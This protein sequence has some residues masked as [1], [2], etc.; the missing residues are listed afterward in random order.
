[1]PVVSA[2]WPRE[3]ERYRAAIYAFGAF[4]TAALL[5]LSD[6]LSDDQHPLGGV[7]WLSLLVAVLAL[8]AVYFPADA[9]AKFVAGVAGA[10]AQTFVGVWT[11]GRI[12]AAELVTVAVSLFVALGIGTMPNAPAN[13]RTIANDAPSAP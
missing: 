3:I 1:M 7:D 9:W 12:T 6:L 4:A 5:K 11:D 2:A 10:V 13:V 8:V